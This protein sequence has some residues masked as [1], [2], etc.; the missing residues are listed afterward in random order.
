MALKKFYIASKYNPTARTRIGFMYLDEAISG[1]NLSALIGAF[2]AM[3]N[4]N[5]AEDATHPIAKVYGSSM[6]I[7]DVQGTDNVIEGTDLT[8]NPI[9]VDGYL[10]GN[11][12]G[13][14]P[15]LDLRQP[16][17]LKGLNPDFT[18]PSGYTAGSLESIS[19]QFLIKWGK[20]RYLDNGNLTGRTVTKFNVVSVYN[21]H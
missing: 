7:V 21:M 16:I 14:D 6:A 10:F 19:E 18:L 20:V 13:L 1:A 12:S 4:G 17:S 9:G 8:T 15:A 11:L 3:S 2:E 5:V